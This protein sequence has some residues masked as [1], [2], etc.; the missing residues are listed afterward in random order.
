MACRYNQ[1]PGVQKTQT[2]LTV[3]RRVKVSLPPLDIT[4]TVSSFT[5]WK[6]TFTHHHPK[7]LGQKPKATT[8]V[9]LNEPPIPPKILRSDKFTSVAHVEP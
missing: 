5:E 7:I 4:T 8:K 6:M 3:A 9:T 2:T 1:H